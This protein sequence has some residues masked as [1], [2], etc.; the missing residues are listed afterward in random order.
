M[1]AL[2]HISEM[3]HSKRSHLNDILEETKAD[4]KYMKILA[5]SAIVVAGTE[6]SHGPQVIRR[7]ETAADPSPNMYST[8]QRRYQSSKG[9]PPLPSLH[10]KQNT[11]AIPRPQKKLFGCAS[12]SM[13]FNPK[14]IPASAPNSRQAPKRVCQKH[15]T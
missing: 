6:R 3:A 12:H 14:L 5:I 9:Q 1:E 11:W 8:W 7:V 4:S 2:I 15:T 10:A 13:R